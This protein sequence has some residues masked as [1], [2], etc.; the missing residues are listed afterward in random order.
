[1][2][3]VFKCL[4]MHNSPVRALLESEK[5]K[6]ENAEKETEKI[7]RET[8]ELMERLRQIEEQTKRAQD[9]LTSFWMHAH[10]HWTLISLL[11]FL[12]LKIKK[13]LFMQQD[14]CHWEVCKTYPVWMSARAFQ[15]WRSR[16]ARP[17][18]LKRKGKSPKRRLSVWTRSAKLRWWWRRPCCNTLRPKS[19]TRKAWYCWHTGNG[20]LPHKLNF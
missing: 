16:L 4:F 17:S 13:G 20:A 7:A 11:L 6:R 18:N 5:K 9:G 15:S 12:L 19:R 8:V 3:L 2:K 1:M 14:L 10:V